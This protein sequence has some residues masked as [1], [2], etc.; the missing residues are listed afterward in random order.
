[1]PKK[2]E[3]KAFLFHASYLKVMEELPEDRR[4][5][6]AIALIEY[7]LGDGLNGDSLLISSLNFEERAA[8]DPIIEAI[9][10]Q[11]RRYENKKMVE[12]AIKIVREQ[13]IET[14]DSDFDNNKMVLEK[15]KMTIE[16]LE[17]KYDEITKHNLN[18]LP[19]EIES[20]LPR[21]LRD[22]FRTRFVIKTWEEQFKNILETKIMRNPQAYEWVTPDIKEQVYIDMVCDFSKNGKL[23]SPLDTYLDHYKAQG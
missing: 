17:Q 23:T 15:Y 21:K 22:T 4:G 13:M 2:S 11:K 1:M 18:I 3:K 5:K 6:I 16:L 20:V 12:G 9:D 8:L 14:M 19:Q 7:G 10:I